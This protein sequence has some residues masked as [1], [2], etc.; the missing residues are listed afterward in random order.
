[1]GALSGEC[2]YTLQGHKAPVRSVSSTLDLK[3]VGTGSEDQTARLWV[4]QREICSVSSLFVLGGHS[5]AV[6]AVSF[7][8][9][10]KWIFTGSS[11]YTVKMWTARAGECKRT[12]DGHR[13]AVFCV[14]MS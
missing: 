10:G 6:N 5:G 7:S 4:V 2:L 8:H 9:D 14:S 1:M 11:D 12:F 3:Y 13:G